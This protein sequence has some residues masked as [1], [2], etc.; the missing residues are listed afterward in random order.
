MPKSDRPIEPGPIP[1]GAAMGEAH[2]HSTQIRFFDRTSVE[3]VK[4]GD[5]AHF[6]RLSRKELYLF[7][8][9]LKADC[10]FRRAPK[11]ARE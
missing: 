8:Y 2:D 6:E 3:V 4:T 1:V 5:P 9:L 11:A 10:A 7:E